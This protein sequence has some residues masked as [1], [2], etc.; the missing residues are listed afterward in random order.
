MPTMYICICMYLYICICRYSYVMNILYIHEYTSEESLGPKSG[1][2]DSAQ[3]G[4]SCS[5]PPALQYVRLGTTYMLYCI[6]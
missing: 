1:V 6:L 4:N 2:E 3:S 5:D